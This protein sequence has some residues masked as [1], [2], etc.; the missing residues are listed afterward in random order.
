MLIFTPSRNI[1][2]CNTK[3]C[4]S[5]YSLVHC[6]SALTC[7]KRQLTVCTNES[8]SQAAFLLELLMI[9]SGLLQVPLLDQEDLQTIINSVC[10]S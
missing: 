1:A 8:A 3:Y 4:N 2:F 9:R 7:F 5:V 10:V 6:R